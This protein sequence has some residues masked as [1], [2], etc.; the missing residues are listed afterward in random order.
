MPHHGSHGSASWRRKW[1]AV[2]SGTVGKTT[3]TQEREDRATLAG[4]SPAY[5]KAEPKEP[6]RVLTE[7]GEAAKEPSC[8]RREGREQAQRG[9][10]RQ[11]AA[12][13][14]DP[15][16]EQASTGGAPPG[17]GGGEALCSPPRR[18]HGDKQQQGRVGVPRGPHHLAPS[19]ELF[20]RQP[21]KCHEAGM[22][23]IHSPLA[24][25]QQIRQPSAT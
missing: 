24:L 22:L 15:G 7:T 20:R 23:L 13:A 9:H 4:M 5:R 21:F 14:S 8:R 19:A 6:R 10:A 16:D 18:E 17:A 11:W 1:S 12:S 3:N 25:S 2:P